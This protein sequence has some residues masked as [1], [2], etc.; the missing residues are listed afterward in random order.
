MDG[1]FLPSFSPPRG[2]LEGS[3]RVMFG[4]LLIAEGALLR[5]HSLFFVFFGMMGLVI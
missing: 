3:F 1:H 5:M 2:F 4:L